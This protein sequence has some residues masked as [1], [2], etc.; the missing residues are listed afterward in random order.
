MENLKDLKNF[1]DGLKRTGLK[2]PLLF[3]GHGSPINAIED[4]E[5]SAG[6][7]K[8]GKELPAPTA[9]LCISA[10]WETN[11]TFITAMEK[12][13]TIH[14]FYGFPE[15]LFEVEYPAA[16]LPELAL[17]TKK[18]ISKTNAELDSKWGL[19]H[20]S[21]SILK[22][23]Y[24]KADVPVIE[25]SIDHYKTP[26]W[27]YELAKEIS[28]L[29]EKGI[30]IIGS[31]NI[32]HNLGMMNWNNPDDKYDWGEEMNEK[33]KLFVNNNEHNSLINYS[34]LG[35]AAKLA[36][37]TPEHF[38]PLLYILGLK[39]EKDQ[40]EFF[41]DRIVLGSISMTSLKIS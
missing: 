19:D 22:H 13:R 7:K 11:G 12:P 21:W 20:G 35:K 2:T 17:E 8:I 6:W 32:V 5:F 34:S 29:R 3:I 41:N 30:L 23:I 10:H 15:K 14:D 40:I 9:V 38:I 28:S 37:P 36:V 4:N 24:P 27:H 39:D 18:L 1:T 31:G 25:L 16:G 26:R 33:F